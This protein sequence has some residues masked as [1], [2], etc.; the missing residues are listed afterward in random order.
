MI[1]HRRSALVGLGSG[2]ITALQP[3]SLAFAAGPSASARLVVVF[4]RGG[5]DGLSLAP[6]YGDS[7]F[8]AIRGPLAD[9]QPESGGP[10]AMRKLDGLFALNP[11][12]SNVHA[13]YNAGEAILFHAMATGYRERSHFD[14]QDALDRGTIDKGMASGW[15][16]RALMHMSIATSQTGNAALGLGPNL[17]LSLRGPQ[18]VANWSP[19][20]QPD[21]SQ[22]TIE[23][24]LRLYDRDTQLKEPFRKGV[25]ASHMASTSQGGAAKSMFETLAS[26]AAGFLAKDDGPRITTIDFGNWDSHSEQNRRNVPGP[27]NANYAGKFPEMYRALDRGLAALKTGLGAAWT[28]TAVL[29]VTEFGRTVHVNGT[30]GTDHGTAGAA[31]LLGGAVRGGRIVADWP[32]LRPSDLRDGR[33]LAPTMDTRSVMKAILQQHLGIPASVVEDTVFPLSRQIQPTAGL[34]RT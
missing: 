2:L 24:L 27:N 6:A 26:A 32:G 17:P 31:L 16:N 23:R 5:V 7:Q 29:V 28:H 4:L 9:D 13:M 12:L 15:L 1:I 14:A 10:F 30:L 11:D 21:V 20:V 3:A 25:E 8:R 22:D 19:P 33:D 34:F 18:R